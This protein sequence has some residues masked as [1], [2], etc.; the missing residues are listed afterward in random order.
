MPKVSITLSEEMWQWW[1]ANKWINLSQLA[2]R[3]LKRLRILEERSLGNCPSCGNAKLKFVDGL[4][5]KCT[6][7]GFVY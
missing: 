2:E 4:H 7:C 1:Q 6:K 3:E 5:Y